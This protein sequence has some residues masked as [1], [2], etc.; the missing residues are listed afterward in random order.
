MPTSW[1]LQM[2]HHVQSDV[3]PWSSTNRQWG[4]GFWVGALWTPLETHQ[5]NV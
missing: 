4:L 5:G 1:T 2:S 3:G